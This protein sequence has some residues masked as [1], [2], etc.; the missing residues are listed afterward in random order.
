MLFCG[1]LLCRRLLSGR[2]FLGRRFFCTLFYVKLVPAG[3]TGEEAEP[4]MKTTIPVSSKRWYTA[5]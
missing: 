4:M 2:L 5:L 1:R 3:L